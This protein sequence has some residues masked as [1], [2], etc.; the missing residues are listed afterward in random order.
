MLLAEGNGKGLY[1]AM[2]QAGISQGICWEMYLR[3]GAVAARRLGAGIE[4]A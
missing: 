2:L 1:E 3:D 4:C